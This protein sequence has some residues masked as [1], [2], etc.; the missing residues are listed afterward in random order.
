MKNGKKTYN[1]QYYILNQKYIGFWFVESS[2]H[3]QKYFHHFKVAL[4]Q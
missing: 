3:D 1:N 2:S 4:Y